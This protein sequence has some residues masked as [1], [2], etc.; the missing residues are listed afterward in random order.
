MR[1]GRKGGNITGLWVAPIRNQRKALLQ[2]LSFYGIP[3]SGKA[4]NSGIRHGH[5]VEFGHQVPGGGS[6]GPRPFLRPALESNK[7][8][9][10]SIF[11][12][13]LAKRIDALVTKLNKQARNR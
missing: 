13:T 2:Y 3:L 1:K 11:K 12:S 9:V 8:E 7:G 5:L 6:V 10:I 4:A